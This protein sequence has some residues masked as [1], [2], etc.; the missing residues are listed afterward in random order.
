MRLND[1]VDHAQFFF[2]TVGYLQFSAFYSSADLSRGELVQK[3]ARATA[4]I[5]V[6]LSL[7][8]FFMRPLPFAVRLIVNGSL[9]ALISSLGVSLL[10][11][12]VQ[13]ILNLSSEEDGLGEEEIKTP[14]RVIFSKA[15]VSPYVNEFKSSNPFTPP[16]SPVE[17]DEELKMRLSRA[18]RNLLPEFERISQEESR[19]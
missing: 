6:M 7:F 3:V 11:K 12:G 14:N 17:N 19:D 16:H 13:K 8:D 15:N 2:E 9:I 18:R 10:L 4:G 1:R 5:F